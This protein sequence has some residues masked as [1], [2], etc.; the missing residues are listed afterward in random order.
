MDLGV[1]LGVSGL[2]RWACPRSLANTQAHMFRGTF[3]AAI[4]SENAFPALAH[5]GGP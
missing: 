3:L 2:G 1:S 5:F 4:S